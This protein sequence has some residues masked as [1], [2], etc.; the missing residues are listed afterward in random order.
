MC[1]S[2]SMNALIN[3]HLNGGSIDLFSSK[4]IG[5]CQVTYSVGCRHTIKISSSHSST[6]YGTKKNA[7]L[8]KMV[9]IHVHCLC[10]TVF[11]HSIFKIIVFEF[12]ALTFKV[13]CVFA[14]VSMDCCCVDHGPLT[15]KV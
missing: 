9:G 2:V 3:F 13:T 4:S 15:L 6:R 8:E 5:Y 12:E 14:S 10:F 1:L 7:R 11:R